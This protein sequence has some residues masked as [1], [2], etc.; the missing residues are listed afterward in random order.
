MQNKCRLRQKSKIV[1]RSSS[2]ILLRDLKPKIMDASH[3]AEASITKITRIPESTD[4]GDYVDFELIKR[5]SISWKSPAGLLR[6][7]VPPQSGRGVSRYSQDDRAFVEAKVSD[8]KGTVQ[9]SI[10]VKK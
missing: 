4:S 9:L 6:F 3:F 7:P 8:Q 10:G 2:E 1:M 5:L